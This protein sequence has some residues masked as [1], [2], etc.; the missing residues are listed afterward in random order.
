[1]GDFWIEKP[2]A[3]VKCDKC[4]HVWKGE[5]FEEYNSWEFIAYDDN[6]CPNCDAFGEYTELEIETEC[7][8]IE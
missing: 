1:M 8:D 4:G 7:V 6:W 3:K 5:I 2:Y